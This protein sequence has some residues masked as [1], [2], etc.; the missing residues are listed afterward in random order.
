MTVS[1]L[2]AGSG[3]ILILIPFF[4]M[5]STS[6]KDPSQTVQFPPIWIPNPIVWQNYIQ[7]FQVVPFARFALN[8]ITITLFAVIG[9]VISGSMVAFSFSRLHWPGRD[10]IFFLIITEMFLPGPVTVIPKF[11]IFRSLGWINTFLPLI[12]PSYFGGGAF[13]IFLMRQFFLT[14]SPELDDAARID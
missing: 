3:A 2:I 1:L 9:V 7:V 13:T 4:F 10:I 11:I 8:T 14:I 5:L 12:V 6:L